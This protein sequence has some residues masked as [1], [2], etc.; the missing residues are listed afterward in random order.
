[1]QEKHNN[2]KGCLLFSML[3]FSEKG[4]DVEDDEALK[5]CNTLQ[6]FQDVFPTKISCQ[7]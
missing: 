6:Q 4:K 7:E 3:I 2:K 5:R 1:M